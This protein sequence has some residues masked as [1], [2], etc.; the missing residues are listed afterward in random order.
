MVGSALQLSNLRSGV[1]SDTWLDGPRE[2]TSPCVG[3]SGDP[4]IGFCASRSA[5][6]GCSPI[7]L[8]F[9]DTV[10]QWEPDDARVSR[11]ILRERGGEIPLRHS[12]DRHRRTEAL[13]LASGRPGRIRSRRNRSGAPQYKGCQAITGQVAEEA[14]PRAEADRHRQAA[15]IWSGKMRRDVGCQTS[16]AQGAEQSRGEFSRAT[17]KTRTNDAGISICRWL[18][19]FHLG[20]LSNKKPLHPAAPEALG[21]CNS[22]PSYPCNGAVENCDRRGSLI[23]TVSPS[24]GF[25][26]TT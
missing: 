19:A 2:S 1:S 10:E 11:P 18:A 9:M 14:R 17:S 24:P 3:I 13:A 23:S 26:Q 20:L 21:A 16:L 15:L 6:L 5:N 8:C 7:G 22:P 25:S 12:G 4:G